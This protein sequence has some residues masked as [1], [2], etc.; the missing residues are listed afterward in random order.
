VSSFLFRE[1]RDLRLDGVRGIA[2]LLVLLYHTSTPVRI[3]P[4]DSRLLPGG[5]VGVDVFF[6]LSGF[7][8]TRLLLVE[9]QAEG[10]IDARAFYLRRVRR[11][12][13]ALVVLLAAWLLVTQTGL[14]PVR[15]LGSTYV[16][17]GLGLA[18]VPVVGAFTLLYNWLL[19][20][21]APTPIGMGHLWTLSVEEQFYVVWL[22]VFVL[23]AAKCARPRRVLWWLVV[24]GSVGSLSLTALE[25]GSSRD[26]AYFSSLTSGLGLLVGAATALSPRLRG[27]NLCAAVG[28]ALIAL[29]ALFV[30]DTAD[31]LLATAVLATCVGT[32]MLICSVGRLDRVL[33]L[34][35]L[36]Y[37]GRR[38]Y[39]MYLWSSPVA[40]ATVV[41]GGQTWAIDV[42]QLGATLVLAE[43]S[44]RLVE[45]RFLARPP[46]RRGASRAQLPVASEPA[47]VRT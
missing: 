18:F 11:L 13:P 33:T 35:W 43:L 10:R 12:M 36:R 5:W 14:L 9:L 44:W 3:L 26:F 31:D 17:P 22:A 30:P 4:A 34:S 28:L 25:A 8:I 41:W 24:G 2:V 19:A 32:A 20:F 38:S 21:D 29:C 15:Q 7:L 6:V 40:Y 46:L 16:D 39:A 27:G 42:V 23:A 37:A 45:R 1:R 47:P